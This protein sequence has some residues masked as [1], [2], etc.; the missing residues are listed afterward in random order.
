M[1]RV[2]YIFVEST[3]QKIRFLALRLILNACHVVWIHDRIKTKILREEIT[4]KLNEYFD[5]G[6]GTFFDTPGHLWQPVPR[7]CSSSVKSWR[8]RSWVLVFLWLV[9]SVLSISVR[10]LFLL[11]SWVGYVLWLRLI[12]DSSFFYLLLCIVPISVL[13]YL[14]IW[15]SGVWV[16]L[17]WAFDFCFHLVFVVV[18]FFPLAA[19]TGCDLRG[20]WLQN[21]ILKYP[22]VY[23]RK[24]VISHLIPMK[25][26]RMI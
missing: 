14:D 9:A 13:Q 10:L 15:Y 5:K 16:R 12:L 22:A 23:Y 26:S 6:I 17:T 19:Y 11:I 18:F 4:L 20:H 3:W 1:R 2:M 21:S 7:Q 25:K 8:R 24:T